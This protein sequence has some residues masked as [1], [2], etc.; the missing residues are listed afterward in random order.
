[1]VA[2]HGSPGSVL[3]I[4][5]A[6]GRSTQLLTGAIGLPTTLAVDP[7]LDQVMVGGLAGAALIDGSTLASTPVVFQSPPVTPVI[8][9]AAMLAGQA[10]PL[11]ILTD[12][13]N[14]TAWLA[15]GSSAAR[16]TS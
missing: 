10:Q 3:A 9:G 11:A 7:T 4:D 6:T 12:S 2:Q 16:F 14:Q 8:A 5:N 1:Y 13:A 15:V